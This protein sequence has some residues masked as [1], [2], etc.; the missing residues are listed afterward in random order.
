MIE[1]D[2][3]IQGDEM[4]EGDRKGRPYIFHLQQAR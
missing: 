4:I 2:D 1:D 3:M